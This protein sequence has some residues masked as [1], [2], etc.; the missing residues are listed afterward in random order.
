MKRGNRIQLHIDGM[1]AQGDGV[2][3]HD[4]R[5]VHVQRTVPGDVVDVVITRKRKGRFEG[6]EVG[7]VSPAME[8]LEPFCSHFDSCGGCRWQHLSYEDQLALKAEMVRRPLMAAG[9]DPGRIATIVPCHEPTFYRNKMEFSFASGPEGE[10]RLG[11]HV[12]GRYNRVFDV[13]ECHLQS[14]IS[15]RIVEAARNEAT[16]RGIPAYDLRSHEG[17]LRFLVIREGKFTEQVMVNLVVAEYPREDVAAMVVAVC[18]KIPEITSFV[19]TKHSGKAQVARGELEFAVAG[20]DTIV[21]R[22]G[23]L[24]YRISTQSFYQTNSHQVVAL[25][26]LVAAQAPPLQDLRVLDLYCGTGGI[27]LHLADRGARVLGIEQEAAAVEDARRNAEA[28][29]LERVEFR[30]GRVEELI[31][32]LADCSFDLVVVDPPRPG[33]HKDAMAALREI[34][35]P[36][37]LYVSCNPVTLAEDLVSLLDA[38]YVVQSVVPI[39]MFPQTPHCEVVVRLARSAGGGEIVDWQPSP[40]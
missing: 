9:I 8:R 23:D 35:A 2:G 22:C 40:E 19:V 26:D 28:N 34:S 12:R 31:G 4:G 24:E 3:W 6:R 17:M 15:N 10:L 37:L 14:Q 11:L 25:Y 1:S 38:G 20:G 32:D 5:E 18:S 27:G 33:L 36:V 21:E 7:L 13:I 29:G 30:S 16:V 39:D